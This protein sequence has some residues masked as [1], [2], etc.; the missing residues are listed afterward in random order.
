[1]LTLD[2][3]FDND[4][5]NLQGAIASCKG[6][7]WSVLSHNHLSLLYKDGNDQFATNNYPSI[8][9]KKDF[10]AM[11]ALKEAGV[12]LEILVSGQQI[13]PEVL[14]GTL[15][16]VQDEK[17]CD[18]RVTLKDLSLKNFHKGH[19]CNIR[20]TEKFCVKTN[21]YTNHID[22]D[23]LNDFFQ[24]VKTSRRLV[25][26]KNFSHDWKTFLLRREL[27]ACGKAVL[28]VTEYRNKRSFVFG[29]F[30]KNNGT[31][32]TA[33]TMCRNI[34]LQRIMPSIS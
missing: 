32:G 9:T 17:F 1:M 2:I 24:A 15:K 19:G 16:C 25:G 14:P 29:V 11:A 6:K 26:Q 5:Q 20:K 18:V 23:L 8:P 21:I 4:M 31:T 27:M 13:L 12:R 28:V 3:F 33:D 30:S 34:L 10:E 22:D 7:N